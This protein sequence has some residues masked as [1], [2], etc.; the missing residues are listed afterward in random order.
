[1]DQ[2]ISS[3]RFISASAGSGKTTRLIGY[4]LQLL[5]R[6]SVSKVLSSHNYCK[7]VCI[8]HTN[9]AVDEISHRLAKVIND[10]ALGKKLDA[11]YV[12]YI[13]EA[14]LSETNIQMFSELYAK[15]DEIVLIKTI[16]GYF[17]AI[18]HI[19]AKIISEEDDKAIFQ[20]VFVTIVRNLLRTHTGN[21]VIE[22]LCNALR[23][24]SL[25][26]NFSLLDSCGDFVYEFT[27][28]WF[29][30]KRSNYMLLKERIAVLTIFS[31]IES[32]LQ[33]IKY[34][35]L[36]DVVKQVTIDDDKT[37][38]TRLIEEYNREN[39]INLL[40]DNFCLAE[41]CTK[42]IDEH[43]KIYIASFEEEEYLSTPFV[44]VDSLKSNVEYKK[45][46][47]WTQLSAESKKTR[48]NDYIECFLTEK[49]EMRKKCKFSSCELS[50]RIFKNEREKIEKLSIAIDKLRYIRTFYGIALFSVVSHIGYSNFKDTECVRSY[51]DIM[52]SACFMLKEE[53]NK[54]QLYQKISHILI[55]EAQ[56]LDSL[57]WQALH[58]IMD[59]FAF[60]DTGKSIFIVGDPN[61]AIFNFH[62]EEI[63]SFDAEFQKFRN[64]FRSQGKDFI[65]N[66][67]S[68]N[69]RSNKS[70]V[71][72]ANCLFSRFPQYTAMIASYDSDGAVYFFQDTT[73]YKEIYLNIPADEGSDIE[74]IQSSSECSEERLIEVLC[75]IAE[76]SNAKISELSDVLVLFRT[77]KTGYEK[78]V[79]AAIDAGFT[80]HHS[81]SSEYEKVLTQIRYLLEFIY[82]P[83]D[84]SN[85]LYALSCVTDIQDIQ[86]D[87]D[88][89]RE[90]SSS[91]WEVLQSK[92]GNEKFVIFLQE[93]CELGKWSEF[94][95]LLILLRRFLSLMN[96]STIFVVEK[97]LENL[98]SDVMC[99]S[100]AE[101]CLRWNEFSEVLF[102][103][104]KKNDRLEKDTGIVFS[105]VH[106]AK[107]MEASHVI[108]A[109]YPFR[110]RN[111]KRIV[112]NDSQEIVLKLPTLRE[113]FYKSVTTQ[114]QCEQMD[115]DKL[116][117]VAVTRAKNYL[118]F[119]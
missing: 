35:E 119:L 100:I 55:D 42:L 4:I 13:G 95:F 40:V 44:M 52:T 14:W 101:L 34:E 67:L 76:L 91:L 56:D 25:E 10:L 17:S 77:A 53:A 9:T 63:P 50:A 109:D 30:K 24:L 59:E 94:R 74:V 16:H 68:D 23:I 118:Y 70:I 106:S 79:R 93:C 54:Y 60:D 83:Y 43:L 78:M 117:Y 6:V 41:S 22:S 49:K 37:C 33:N 113:S 71:N 107:G 115:L 96:D 108:I 15:L 116:L 61:Q 48:F 103:K 1:M 12:S 29:S 81:A 111:R 64:H 62:N 51:N 27:K 8:T 7:I 97:L 88:S 5:S 72:F 39:P 58:S 36:L 20:K 47:E 31:D 57:Q 19:H 46:I 98:E 21:I 86:N 80:A 65:R 73:A 45:F 99:T 112:I 26:L 89:E 82:N 85:L 69:C 87:I 28:M 84:N 2:N 90:H 75:R 38:I 11:R 114:N 66:K 92:R 18:S 104:L 3:F 102:K 32:M 105:T 110:S